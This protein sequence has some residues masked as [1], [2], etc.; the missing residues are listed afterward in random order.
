MGKLFK[1]NLSFLFCQTR[2]HTRIRW[3]WRWIAL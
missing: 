1:R 3:R 2:H